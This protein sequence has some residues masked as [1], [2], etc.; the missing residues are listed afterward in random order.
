MTNALRGSSNILENFRLH[1]LMSF[2]WKVLEAVLKL[3][4]LLMD[5]MRKH[6]EKSDV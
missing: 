6:L 4:G 2:I 3:K 1:C 5:Q